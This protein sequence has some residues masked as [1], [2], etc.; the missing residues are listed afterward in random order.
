MN[1][2]PD[3]PDDCYA[4]KTSWKSTEMEVKEASIILERC[5]ENMKKGTK[6]FSIEIDGSYHFHKEQKPYY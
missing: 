4:S 1:T 6:K 2:I 5:A 3:L